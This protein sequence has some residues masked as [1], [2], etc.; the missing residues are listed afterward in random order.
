M[1]ELKPRTIQEYKCD[2]CYKNTRRKQTMVRHERI[3]FKNPNRECETC[4]NSGFIEIFDSYYGHGM[5]EKSCA[6]CEEAKEVG[7]K[8]YI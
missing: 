5:G 8:S 3:C 6:S 2:F 4:Q 7:G 1:R